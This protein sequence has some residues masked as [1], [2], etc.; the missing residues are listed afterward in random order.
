[1]IIPMTGETLRAAGIKA[2]RG[3]FVA[4]TSLIALGAGL[5]GL[6]GL[7]LADPAAPAAAGD[8]SGTGDA[9]LEQITITAQKYSSTVQNTPISISAL[10]GEQLEAAGITHV[11]QVL[12]DVPGL[13]MRYGGPGEVE[14][15]ARGL[16]STG[17]ASPTVGFY[18]DEI[19]L[20]PPALSQVG[21]VVIDPDLY[22]VSRIEVLRGPQ[23]TL[24]GSGSMGGT[25]RIITNKPELNFFDASAQGTVSGTEG[26]GANGGGDLMLNL[27]IGETLALRLV[28]SDSYRSGWID[29]IV[30][31]P[32]PTGLTP[33]TTF[34]IQD[35]PSQTVYPDVNTETLGGGRATLLWQP[36]EDLSVLTTV[37]YQHLRMGGYDTFDSPPGPADLAHYEAFPIREPLIDYA[38]IYSLTVTDHL[39]FADLTSATAFWDRRQTQ[40]EDASWSIYYSNGLTAGPAFLPIPYYEIDPSH[41]FSEELRL[42]SRGSDRLHWVT[43]AFLSDLHS[44]WIEAG[45]NPQNTLNPLGVYFD[46][47]NPYEVKQLALFADGTWQI[48]RQWSFS[49]GLRWYR[50]ASRQIEDEWGYDAPS[51]LP[52]AVEPVTKAAER[53]FNP[54]FDLSYSPSDEL[55]TYLSASK[56]FR[57]GGAN[58]VFPPPG[59]PP[60]CSPAPLSFGPDSVWDYELG[61]KAR[62]LGGW[63]TV[64]SDV[65]Y[66]RWNDIQQ[67]LLLGCGYEYN[68]NAGNGRS[69]GPELEINAKLSEEW[70]VSAS[71][72]YTDSKITHPSA[73]YVGYLTTS[74]LAPNGSPW[75]ASATGCTA[76]IL[77][78]P[79]ETASA[80]LVYTRAIADYTLTA[81]LSDSFV[82]PSFDESYYFGIPLPSY[83]ILRTRATL[84]HGNWSVDLFIDNLTDKVA[85]LTANNTSFQFNVPGLIRYSTNQPRTFGTQINYRF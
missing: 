68:S 13:S 67:A 72:A 57:P 6:C 4:M 77:D 7:C 71:G 2:A 45:S 47:I 66:I 58:L 51:P 36:S 27:P 20:S 18:L 12:E 42:S 39:G 29:R 19:P 74:A 16:A 83:N 54:R 78:I 23:G 3:K 33:A 28:G 49:T 43:G 22:D 38:K 32:Y 63:L 79:K 8:A 76:P 10:S 46:A 48:A 25:I 14:Y 34:P 52:P 30:V 35:A 40:D 31:S 24:Y 11:D 62:L 44:T 81:R 61:E 65:Y 56:G 55:T 41:Q 50:Y 82:G 1:M 21:K 5:A 75:C 15:E 59:E 9:G 37:M 17:G 69:L 85:E 53:G 60:Y 73:A 80:T 26:G 70:A 64:N 84:L